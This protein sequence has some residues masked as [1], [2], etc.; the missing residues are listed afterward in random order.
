[1][2]Y[3]AGVDPAAPAAGAHCRSTTDHQ[4]SARD[5]RD[6]T[7]S[8]P[9]IQ[10]AA[11][12]RIGCRFHAENLCF[13]PECRKYLL[14]WA[15][16]RGQSSSSRHSFL[17][18]TKILT[19][20]SFAKRFWAPLRRHSYHSNVTSSSSYWAAAGPKSTSP[21]F[22]PPPACPPTTTSNR[23]PERA[24]SPPLVLSHGQSWNVSVGIAL[25]DRS[26]ATFG[27][28]R[29]LARRAH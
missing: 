7:H 29:T 15:R 5:W 2:S 14:L 12:R 26:I 23:C 17:P 16:A 18:I 9:V 13:P 4:S 8:D 1:M 22:R 3:Q 20:F 19:G 24:A 27:S 11:P 25:F 28:R 6:H 21:I 10:S